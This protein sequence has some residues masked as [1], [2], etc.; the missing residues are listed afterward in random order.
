MKIVAYFTMVNAHQGGN[1][2]FSFIEGNGVRLPTLMY[3]TL[4][5]T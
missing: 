4:Q 3:L 1:H 5:R 2:R